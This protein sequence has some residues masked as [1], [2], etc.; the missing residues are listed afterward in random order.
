MISLWIKVVTQNKFIIEGDRSSPGAYDSIYT[1]SLHM[2]SYTEY[3]SSHILISSLLL[4]SYFQFSAKL[5]M[6][7]EVIKSAT[8]D[9]VF[10]IV[11]FMFYTSVFA[12]IAHLIFGQ[13]EASLR[14]LNE[15]MMTM[16]LT[17]VGERSPFTWETTL[18]GM[19]SLFG[20]VF[21]LIKVFL[22]NMFI[23][24]ITAHYI[25]FYV[26]SGEESSIIKVFCFSFIF[27]SVSLML[28]KPK[29]LQTQEVSVFALKILI[30]NVFRQ[31]IQK[32]ELV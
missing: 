18:T 11:I 27:F 2:K 8:V 32:S 10:F 15:A 30:K 28:F 9:I 5:S 24:V 29:N 19:R 21:I 3:V 25:E 7:Y 17:I 20:V 4:M 12:L 14:S 22:L 1:Q 26:E 23:A 16:F 6:F 13:T 31:R